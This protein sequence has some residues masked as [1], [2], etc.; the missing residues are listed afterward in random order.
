MLDLNAKAIKASINVSNISCKSCTLL[1]YTK[2]ETYLHEISMFTFI[3]FP[4]LLGAHIRCAQNQ[5]TTVQIDLKY[6]LLNHGKNS[7]KALLLQKDLKISNPPPLLTKWAILDYVNYV[8]QFTKFLNS[9][10]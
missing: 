10:Q 6:P 8:P 3:F 9:G 7:L 5:Y 1:W 4:R 2:K